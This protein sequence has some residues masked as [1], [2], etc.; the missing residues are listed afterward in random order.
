MLQGFNISS[1]KLSWIYSC[2]VVQISLVILTEVKI[3]ILMLK[4][5]FCW[6]INIPR[7]EDQ[8]CK[9]YLNTIRDT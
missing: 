9:D 3:V 4:L 2:F 7:E 5:A 1:F 8:S 6:D